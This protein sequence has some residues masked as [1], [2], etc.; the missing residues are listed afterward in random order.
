MTID[1]LHI[2]GNLWDFN[3]LFIICSTRRSVSGQKSSGPDLIL[4]SRTSICNCDVSID[5]VASCFGLYYLCGTWFLFPL[6]LSVSW[7]VNWSAVILHCC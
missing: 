3:I 5:S 7:G 2:L 4:F 6:P 1:F